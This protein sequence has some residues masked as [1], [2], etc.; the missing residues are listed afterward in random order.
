VYIADVAAEHSGM[1]GRVCRVS[2]KTFGHHGH[3]WVSFDDKDDHADGQ[4][5]FDIVELDNYGKHKKQQQQ[6]RTTRYNLD[7]L[8]CTDMLGG[9]QPVRVVDSDAK[10]Y[11]EIGRA[12]HW[13]GNDVYVAF[14]GVTV[15]LL[16]FS[17]KR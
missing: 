10:H 4:S 15:R 6:R 9:S 11:L 5:L 13:E 14:P 8:L 3:A 17:E 1:I 2:H 12:V 7:Q 16:I